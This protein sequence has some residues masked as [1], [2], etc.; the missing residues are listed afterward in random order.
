MINKVL[1]IGNL[2]KDAETREINDTLSVTSFSLATSE[3]YKDKSGEWQS[4]TQWHNIKLWNA[5]NFIKNL[6]KGQQVYVEGS[7]EYTSSE[8]S[9]G[10]V[11][12]YTDIK[13]RSVRPVGGQQTG[14][15]KPRQAATVG[16]IDEPTDD[17]P[18]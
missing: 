2:G 18:F 15:D 14:A 16:A 17:L 9:D 3:S 7:I 1:L 8:D 4:K 11:R 5:S 6:Q 12:Y 13:A 10:N